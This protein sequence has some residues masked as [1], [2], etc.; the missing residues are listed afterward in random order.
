MKISLVSTTY[1]NYKFDVTDAGPITRVK[2]PE[3]IK[4][5][6]TFTVYYGESSKVSVVWA[7]KNGIEGYLIGDVERSIILSD[8]WKEHFPVNQHIIKSEFKTITTLILGSN[9][10]PHPITKRDRF[11]DN[12]VCVQLIKEKPMKVQYPGDSL[13]LDK[14]SLGVLKQYQ[15]LDH[16]EHEY[17][18]HHPGAD[19]RVFSIVS[20]EERFLVM[21]YS[22][23]DEVDAKKGS[24][25]A[26][27]SYYRQA[28]E[29]K[30][31]K[32]GF[33]HTIKI[34]DTDKDQVTI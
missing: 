5:G 22:N 29:V 7:G 18:R 10:N 3:S 17:K 19:C 25:L 14:N 1:G 11:L 15:Q 21:G 4:K 8:F 31:E 9:L 12:G 34:F 23:Q 20:E 16:D 32:S 27:V 24:F 33:Y 6:E 30:A 28:L 13:V 2:I 26:G